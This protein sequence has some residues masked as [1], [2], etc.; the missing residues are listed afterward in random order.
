MN[1]LRSIY[2]PTFGV[3]VVDLME[4][5]QLF[6]VFTSMP[7]TI[8]LLVLAISIF[9]CTW[10]E[11]RGYG[12]S[13]PRSGSSSRPRTSTPRLP[14][15]VS[16]APGTASVPPPGAAPRRHRFSVRHEKP[17]PTARQ[18]RQRPQPLDEARDAHLHPGLILF[19]VAGLVRRDSATSRGSS[20]P[21]ATR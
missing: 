5:L 21:R 6:H 18:R 15:R 3:P 7:F 10:T 20:W 16:I 13:R 19:L 17:A 1:R 2:E 8:A 14:D 11:R 9:L 4:R 12:S